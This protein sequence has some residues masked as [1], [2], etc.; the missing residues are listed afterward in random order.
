MTYTI[1]YGL[2]FLVEI[3]ISVFYFETK[4]DRKVSKK[5]YIQL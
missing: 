3:L 1:C 5:F 4:F 2:I